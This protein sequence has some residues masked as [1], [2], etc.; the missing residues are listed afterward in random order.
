MMYKLV[1]GVA[2]AVLGRLARA[3]P[4]LRRYTVEHTF[5]A[6][7]PYQPTLP[8]NMSTVSPRLAQHFSA[9]IP[10]APHHI[11]RLH[12]V[13][14]TWDGAVFQNLRVFTPSVVQAQFARRFQDTL[15]LRQWVGEKVVVEATSV[16]VCHDQ[17]S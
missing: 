3:L 14:V 2:D 8:C 5:P 13:H 17:W 9:I 11:Y 10:F 16:A 12:N 4:A 1:K 15:L 7:A 6:R